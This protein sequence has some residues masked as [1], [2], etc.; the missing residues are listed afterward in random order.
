MAVRAASHKTMGYKA[1]Q[2]VVKILQGEKASNLPVT[3]EHKMDLA[4]NLTSASKVGITLPED[5]KKEARLVN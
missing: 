3:I 5:L 2:M 4:I 1:G